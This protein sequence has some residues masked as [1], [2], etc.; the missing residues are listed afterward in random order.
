MNSKIY[1]SILIIFLL[2]SISVSTFGQN[3]TYDLRFKIHQVDCSAMKVYFDVELRAEDAATEF[4]LSDMNFRFS[5][6]TSLGNPQIDQELL[7]S[8]I[9]STNSPPTT[10]LYE[11]HTL[12]GS[13]DSVISYNITLSG[14]DGYPV[15]AVNYIPV[16]RLSLDILDPTGCIFLRWHTKAPEDFPPTFVGEK[17]NNALYIGNEASYGN[18]NHCTMCGTAPVTVDDTDTTPPGVLTPEC[19]LAN[20]SDPDGPLDQNSVQ[21][22]T[23]IPVSEGTAVY[24]ATTGCIDFTSD[25]GFTGPIT[26][27]VYE[28]CDFGVPIPA[29]KGDS[30]SVPVS[31]PDPM[32]SPIQSTPLC[33]TGN[34]DIDVQAGGV[35]LSPNLMLQGPYDSGTG[36]MSSA[37]LSG[38][39]YV[40][41]NQPYSALGIHSGSEA[42]TMGVLN[43]YSIVDWVL[44][45]LR[46][47]ADNT[48]ILETRA[49]LLHPTGLVTDVDGI[50]PVAFTLASGSYYV[51]VRHRNHLPVA[52]LNTFAMSSTTTTVDFK[53]IPLFGT[54]AAA[55]VAGVQIL[56]S[57]NAQI[58]GSIDAADRSATWN[59]RNQAGYLESDCD[60]DG[61]TSASD[62]SITWNNR[63][64]S[65]QLP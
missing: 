51:A 13:A 55:I 34:L 48:S 4:N 24:N 11:T 18:Y 44:V 23:N 28:V 31:S 64:I 9:V 12:T 29:T 20:D 14:G 2:L 42:V 50:N 5:F 35:A 37:S 40:P 56:W 60:L 15:D 1:N 58:D 22:I 39:G 46:D 62:R 8:G 65:A 59:S 41:L 63:N 30:N 36:E 38:Q 27:I 17:F 53:S 19:I 21:I 47:G 49:A 54:N 10:S 52:S 6:G 33:A 43:A 45:E 26:T 16:G 61:L 32:D 25:P 57:G 7:I 3:G